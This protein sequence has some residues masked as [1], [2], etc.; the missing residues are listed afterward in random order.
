MN[1]NEEVKK[2]SNIENAILLDVRMP[3]E[4][5][6]GHIPGSQNLP[7]SNIVKASEHFP[8]KNVPIFTYCQSG[9]RS[10]RAATVLQKLGYTNVTN[11]G[12]I[13]HYT[14]PIEK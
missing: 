12:G 4:Y 7:L 11:I 1:I 2:L 5:A 10:T 3:D 9:M 6:A 13:S 14:G 8:N